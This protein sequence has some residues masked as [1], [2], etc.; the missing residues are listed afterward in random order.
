MS[1]QTHMITKDEVLKNL[2][3]ALFYLFIVI[4]Y[5][6]LNAAG[7]D[8]NVKWFLR[9]LQLSISHLALLGKREEIHASSGQPEAPRRGERLHVH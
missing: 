6:V 1:F 8:T 5:I 9:L 7:L 4:L 3:V 2:Q